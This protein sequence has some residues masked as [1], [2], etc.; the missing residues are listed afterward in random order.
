V[1]GLMDAGK[2][3]RACGGERNGVSS[4]NVV[5]G[6]PARRL[7]VAGSNPDTGSRTS[8]KLDR[9]VEKFCVVG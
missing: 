5:G 1:W 8:H 3:R 4:V 9:V 6:M 2:V 7:A